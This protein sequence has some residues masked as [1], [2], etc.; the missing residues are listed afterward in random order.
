[1]YTSKKQFINPFMP[2]GI[3]HCYQLDQSISVLRV[4]GW[5]FSF[6]NNIFI[7]HSVS[8]QCRTRSDAALSGVW[9]G[10][11]VFANVSQKK[12]LGL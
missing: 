8:K 3:S 4:V 6:F 5:Y 7:G 10:S 1:M 2:G 9:S 12:T 11:A